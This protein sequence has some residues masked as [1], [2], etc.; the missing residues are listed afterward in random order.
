M[1][2]IT[3]TIENTTKELLELMGIEFSLKVKDADGAFEVQIDSEETGMLIGYHGETLS[4]LQIILGL[5]VHR[6]L[7]E[8]Q[9]VTVNVGDYLEKRFRQL[10][11]M[12][13]S[14]VDQ[15]LD[16]QVS[17]TLPYLNSRERRHIHLYL[18]KIEGIR[19]ESVGEDEERRL[20]V[21]PVPKTRS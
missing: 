9:R 19:T 8:W 11:S 12:A 6:K 1:A 13:D 5:L 4:A 14:A 15:A 17:V 18:G 21:F 20:V 10:E 16:E 2:N 7:G 3:Q